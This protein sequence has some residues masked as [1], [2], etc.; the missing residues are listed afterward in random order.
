MNW[1][2]IGIVLVWAFF[3]AHGYTKG[4]LRMIFS[5]ISW[6]VM[7]AVSLWINP[8][9]SD[10]I[11]QN[12]Q[13]DEEFEAEC[14]VTLSEMVKEAGGEINLNLPE[15][16]EKAIFG[17]ENIADVLLENTGVYDEVAHRITVFAMKGIAFFTSMII[18]S[19]VLI[20]IYM[21]IR[22]VEKAP[23]ISQ[24]NHLLGMALGAVKGLVFL[25]VVFFI[26]AMNTT[27]AI[28]TTLIPLINESA[29]LKF[30]YENNML[31][32]LLFAI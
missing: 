22:V 31:I 8:Y 5:L 30:M 14:K 20:I 28:G 9:V 2:L 18:L 15:P 21:M 16:L 12:T 29:F 24:M 23:V 6:I 11:I 1:L 4:M 19:I 25:W 26:V 32:S 17:E 10:F 27:T 13:I 7:L 3:I